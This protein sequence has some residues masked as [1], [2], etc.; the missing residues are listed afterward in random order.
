MQILFSSFKKE[1]PDFDFDEA[2]L[3]ANKVWGKA[4]NWEYD[5]GECLRNSNNLEDC[6]VIGRIDDKPVCAAIIEYCD[7]KKLALISCIGAYPEKCGYGSLLMK[8]IIKNLKTSKITEVYFK[9]I[10]DNII[11]DNE[12]IRLEKFC[13][14]FG[15]AKVN[16]DIL[17]NL[18][19]NLDRLLCL[20]LGWEY[21]MSR[22]L[23]L[24]LDIDLDLDLDITNLKID[25]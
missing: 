8:N 10:R 4:F 20:D 6:V 19:R 23:D 1:D 14:K 5:A 16:E 3:N 11:R 7:D 13:S 2:V 25:S 21:V 24:D 18:D 9:I 12:A 22:K 15:F 17:F